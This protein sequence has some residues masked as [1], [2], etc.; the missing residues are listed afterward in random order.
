VQVFSTPSPAP[1]LW[2][3]MSNSSLSRL[4]ATGTGLPPTLVT[5]KGIPD[6]MSRPAGGWGPVWPWATQKSALGGLMLSAPDGAS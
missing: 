4:S 6:G 2:V 3:T 5:V 1:Q